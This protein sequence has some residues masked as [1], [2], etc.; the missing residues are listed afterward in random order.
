MLMDVPLKYTKTSQ[1]RCVFHFFHFSIYPLATLLE[2]SMHLLTYVII[3]S[4]VSYFSAH[5]G[6]KDTQYISIIERDTQYI[7]GKQ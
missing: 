2:A 3:Q 5:C 4:D 1:C 6:G 7:S